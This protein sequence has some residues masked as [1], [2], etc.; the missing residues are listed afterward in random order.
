MTVINVDLSV[1]EAV[2][3]VFF[4]IGCAYLYTFY[5]TFVLKTLAVQF[6]L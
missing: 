6:I 2:K 3:T 4:S 5:I 1:D